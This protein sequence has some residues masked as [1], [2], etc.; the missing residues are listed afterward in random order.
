MKQ[1]TKE[2]IIAAAKKYPSSQ[3]I[4]AELW[5]DAFDDNTP[6]IKIGQL[7]KRKQYEQSVYSVF[8]DRK[9]NCVRILNITNSSFWSDNKSIPFYELKDP[10]GEY[11]TVSEFKRLTELTD[12]E[13]ITKLGYDA[14]TCGFRPIHLINSY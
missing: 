13:Q 7:F 2:Q 10:N 12:L 5:P 1:P 9:S 11:L 8:R 4:L 3:P 6:Y 14:T